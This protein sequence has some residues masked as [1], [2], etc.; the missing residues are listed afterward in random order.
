M[1]WS[2]VE[3]V[4]GGVGVVEVEMPFPEAVALTWAEVVEGMVAW[5]GT[6]VTAGA[7]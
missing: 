4:V 7:V 6:G 2:W 3:E 1:A 5:S